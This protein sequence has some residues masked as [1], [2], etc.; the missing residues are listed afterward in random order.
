LW[1]LNGVDP[2]S[3]LKG[4][5]RGWLRE[6]SVEL[7]VAD[8]V[9]TVQLSLADGDLRGNIY[10]SSFDDVLAGRGVLKAGFTDKKGFEAEI[11]ESIGK[12]LGFT[13]LAGLKQEEFKVNLKEETVGWQIYSQALLISDDDFGD[14]LFP[15]R[16]LGKYRRDTLGM[17]LGLD[18]LEATSK[19]KLEARRADYAYQ[20][21]KQRLNTNAE[22]VKSRLQEAETKLLDMETQITRLDSG[23][24][25][26]VNPDYLEGLQQKVAIYS[27]RVEEL[28]RTHTQIENEHKEIER[29][30]HETERTRL[31]LHETMRFRVFLSGLHVEICPHCERRLEIVS[32]TEEIEN[33]ICRVCHSELRPIQPVDDYQTLLDDAQ[34]KIEMLGKERKRLARLRKKLED[35]LK[36]AHTE[37]AKES[38]ALADA[39]RQAQTGFTKEFQSLHNQRGYWQ[40]RVEELR[41]FT[42]EGQAESLKQIKIK[43]EVLRIAQKHLQKIMGQTNDNL[44][45]RLAS[46]TAEFAR[47]FGLSLQSISLSENYMMLVAQ[48]DNAPRPFG[49]F[50][51]SERL[52]I[53]FAFHLSLLDLRMQLGKGRHPGLLI[54]DAPFPA[55]LDET[56]REEMLRALREIAE[57]YGDSLQFLIAT[58]ES[59]FA[60][61]TKREQLEEKVGKLF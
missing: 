29:E 21:E 40:G 24:S 1:A 35:D 28:A 23:Q 32:Q 55:E 36:E 61:I 44:R 43:T 51:L 49:T 27:R 53:K 11:G 6:V 52:R 31:A 19:V 42:L 41:S 37:Y 25:V 46:R 15:Q 30:F 5:I 14:Y 48:S 4:D 59:E 20:L 39:S 60:G 57:R 7:N 13:S 12:L 2:D 9:F 10:A 58:T 38:A 22:Q 3:K 54:L 16:D 34:A 47:Q 18:L 33:G 26:L 56:H 8:Q 45:Q 50:T 17:Y